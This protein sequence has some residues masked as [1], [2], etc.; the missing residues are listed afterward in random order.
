[1]FPV[2][3]PLEAQ[4]ICL[5]RLS[6][7]T[8]AVYEFAQH[9]LLRP[10]A[11]TVHLSDPCHLILSF[12]LFGDAIGGCHLPDQQFKLFIGLSINIL[13]I[14]VQPAGG[15]KTGIFI[16]TTMPSAQVCVSGVF[17]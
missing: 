14:I 2:L 9:I 12:H 16:C 17:L 15:Q 7:G 8:S 3:T 4:D 10:E 1:M 11:D 5:S 6:G 13:Q